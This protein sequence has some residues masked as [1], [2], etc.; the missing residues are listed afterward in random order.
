[1]LSVHSL[2]KSQSVG[3][4]HNFYTPIPTGLPNEPH[5]VSLSVVDN[6]LIT[7]KQVPTECDRIVD[8]SLHACLDETDQ[9]PTNLT[10]NQSESVHTVSDCLPCTDFAN[11]G[12][13]MAVTSPP[14]SFCD[15]S[16]TSAVF[17]DSVH[18]A[19]GD[20]LARRGSHQCESAPSQS[21]MRSYKPHTPTDYA[22]Y[23][24]AGTNLISRSA[25]NSPCSDTPSSLTRLSLRRRAIPRLPVTPSRR[26][27]RSPRLLNF[28][29]AALR[30]KVPQSNL[31]EK[32]VN[33]A[34][35]ISGVQSPL[36]RAVRSPPHLENPG[37]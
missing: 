31:V 21:P 9:I 14:D 8:P 36:T 1:M 37:L 7:N 3:L 24:L 35:G 25:P 32:N 15:I 12:L 5:D 20:T 23:R 26:M 13:K 2:N 33:V 34:C 17:C 30:R 27:P 10:Y 22:T 28:S 29:P 4:M 19:F 6:Q 11:A 16:L 18:V